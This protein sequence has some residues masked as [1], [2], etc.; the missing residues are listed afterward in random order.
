[1][2]WNRKI[3]KNFFEDVICFLATQGFDDITFDETEKKYRIDNYY[4]TAEE[5]I[6][7]ANAIREKLNLQSFD[8]KAG[9]KNS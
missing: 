7:I 5:L 1:M 9:C 2:R 3:S 4:V 8:P 6:D